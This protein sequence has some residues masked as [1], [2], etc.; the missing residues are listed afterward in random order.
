MMLGGFRRGMLGEVSADIEHLVRDDNAALL[1]RQ[2]I[3]KISLV[4]GAVAQIPALARLPGIERLREL[5]IRSLDSETS[6]ALLAGLPL[7]RLEVLLVLADSDV[8]DALTR[9]SLPRLRHLGCNQ[10]GIDEETFD[11]LI[12]A[13]GPGL[14]ALELA[15]TRLRPEKLAAISRLP[16]EIL[17]LGGNP[18][19]EATATLPATLR[20]L[21]LGGCG[22]GPDFG[23]LLGDP[24]NLDELRLANNRLGDPPIAGFLRRRDLDSLA[25]LDLGNNALSAE[26]MAALRDN[27]W[28]GR[29]RRLRLASNQLGD[30]IRELARTSASSLCSLD[31]SDTQLDDDGLDALLDSPIG[32]ALVHLDIANVGLT[33]RSVERLLEPGVAPSLR[34]LSGVNGLSISVGLRGAL[35]DRFAV[36]RDRFT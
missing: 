32:R 30:G 15:E 14:V 22:L 6:S 28:L 10:S 24:R 2:P 7:S 31:V 17:E 8:A 23:R 13:R 19:G 25:Q 11:A 29:L 3:E 34:W 16:L 26:S 4:S 20:S 1:A 12:V 21:D 18:I 27:G 5:D 36:R 35:S 33:D 9:T